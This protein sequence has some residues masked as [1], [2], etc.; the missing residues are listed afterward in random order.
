MA[1]ELPL[2]LITGAAGSVGT[3]LRNHWNDAEGGPLYRL[4]L[5]DLAA[6][7]VRGGESPDLSATL[8]EHEE[9]VEFDCADYDAFLAACQGVHAVVHLA[10]DPSPS[11]EFYGS[12][13][14]RNIIGERR[15][16]CHTAARTVTVAALTAVCA[17]S[18][19]CERQ[20]TTRSARWLQGRIMPLK[21]RL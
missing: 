19:Q 15:P 13:L 17:Q 12:L 16:H 18:A 20:L 7:R 2:V 11:A 9:A 14:Q 8:A 5:A 21:L 3:I 4:R 1:E 10:A 6:P